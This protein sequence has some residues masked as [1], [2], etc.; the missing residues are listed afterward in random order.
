MK[1]LQPQ[2]DSRCIS[3]NSLFLI[4]ENTC[5]L[6]RKQKQIYSKYLLLVA[7]HFFH[8]SGN[9]WIP[10]QKNS[11]FEANHSSSHFI[12]GRL[13]KNRSAAQRA[14]GP[15]T[16]T[17]GSRKEPGLVNKR[18]GVASPVSP[19]SFGPFLTC[20]MVRCG[21]NFSHGTQTHGNGWLSNTQLLGKHFLQLG[22]VLVQKSLQLM[23]LNLPGPIF[24]LLVTQV[25]IAVF[26]PNE[27]N[28]YML[29]PIKYC[30]H[31]S[32]RAFDT[33]RHSISSN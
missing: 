23:V 30:Y 28:L 14:R 9:L 24:T 29:F 4:Q 2:G 33:I 25:K 17:S 12:L 20:A 13:R 1:L 18:H 22:I 11:S 3:S 27:I 26:E 8:F 31:R 19:S 16:K 5:F 21:G 32:P 7:T 6:Y 10:R 15:L